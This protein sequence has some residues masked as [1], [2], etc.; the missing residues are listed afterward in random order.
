MARQKLAQG[1]AANELSRIISNGSQ[2]R[3]PV[4]SM[5]PSPFRTMFAMVASSCARQYRARAGI[6]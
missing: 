3:V 1:I 4:G 2:P 6:A 5:P